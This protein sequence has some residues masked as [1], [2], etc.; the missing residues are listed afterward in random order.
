MGGK[1]ALLGIRALLE[2]ETQSP[3]AGVGPGKDEEDQNQH[4]TPH[5]GGQLVLAQVELICGLRSPCSANA[6]TTIW[7][8][9][10]P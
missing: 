2:D 7:L 4:D 3:K 9:N 8:E 10:H 5:I 1:V 6:R